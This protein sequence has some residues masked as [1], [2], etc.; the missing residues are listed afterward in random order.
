M[1]W[2][3][4]EELFPVW[5]EPRSFW[6]RT[7]LT[8][9]QRRGLDVAL[10]GLVVLLLFGWTYTAVDALRTG[11]VPQV[12]RRIGAN[13]TPLSPEAP[14]ATA[15]LLD[16]ALRQFVSA[17]DFHGHSG[18]VRVVIRQP[19]EEGPV[20][21]SLPAGVQPQYQPVGGVETPVSTQGGVVPSEPGLWNVLLQ[22]KGA[23]RAVPNL[24]LVTL[25]P[26]SSVRAGK[27]G[28]YRMGSWPDKTG[29]Y[30]PPSGFVRV[31][32]ENEDTYVSEHI[33]LKD[34]LTKGQANVWPKYVA[35]S[36]RLLDKLELTFQEM[37]KEGHPVENIFAISG[38]RTPT[39]NESGGDPSGRAS[40]SRHMY[41]DAMDVAIDNDHDGY[42]DDL[43]GDGK[44]NTED[45][46]V[47]GRAAQKV[48][49]AYPDLV[50]GIG[51][52]APTGGHHGFVHI[53][54]RGYRARWGPW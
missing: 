43:N 18:E 44:V 6:E 46:R 14:P 11:D 24:S 3:S 33:Q 2:V 54:T 15:F 17:E 28:S 20:P 5:H 30:A 37:E 32:P 35:M 8:A 36:P 26:R 52:Y 22:A 53:D 12:A 49:Q 7:G 13:P 9:E 16:A 34:F 41:G 1:A 39:Y 21:D 10:V 38:F 40:L 25:V 29:N 23:I 51:I 31:T 4:N 45:A 42:M 50:G 19:G 27:L 48:E 47:L